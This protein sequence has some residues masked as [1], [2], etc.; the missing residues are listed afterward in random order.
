MV[1]SK[2]NKAKA[3]SS[4][5]E[6]TDGS[7]PRGLVP[8][9]VLGVAILVVAIMLVGLGLSGRSIALPEFAVSRIEARAN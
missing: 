8:W 5:T 1:K 9:L 7:V 3:G 2:N 6:R 4:A